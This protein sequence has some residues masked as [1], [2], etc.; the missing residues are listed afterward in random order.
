[1]RRNWLDL[2]VGGMWF[3]IESKG[4]EKKKPRGMRSSG[5]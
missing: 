5:D 4:P 1:M 3:V 2:G